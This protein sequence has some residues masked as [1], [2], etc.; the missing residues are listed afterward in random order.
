MTYEEALARLLQVAGNYNEVYNTR[1][2]N[3]AIARKDLEQIHKEVKKLIEDLS[4]SPNFLNITL[5]LCGYPMVL[6]SRGNVTVYNSIYSIQGEDKEEAIQGYFERLL[7]SFLKNYIRTDCLTL[8]EL[9]RT[10]SYVSLIYRSFTPELLETFSSTIQ[11]WKDR[12]AE[13]D[14]DMRNFAAYRNDVRAAVE[15]VAVCW[16]KEVEIL[17][18]MKLSIINLKTRTSEVR[19]VKRVS[20]VDDVRSISFKENSSIIKGDDRIKGVDSWLI[21]NP[22]Y[23]DL[24]KIYYWQVF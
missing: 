8:E 24:S 18:D 2:L 23:S 13:D 9:I 22:E 4:P 19:T 10:N 7:L 14:K 17:P 1:A 12:K 11:K 20:Y 3:G 21:N 6:S 15:D 16:L 5:D